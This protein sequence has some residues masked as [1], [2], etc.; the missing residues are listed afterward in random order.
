ME[1]NIDI[2]EELTVAESILQVASKDG[3]EPEIF[4]FAVKAMKENPNLSIIEA[5]YQGFDE[6]I[7]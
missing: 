5:M 2:L 4:V 1:E 7:K 3:L 6:W